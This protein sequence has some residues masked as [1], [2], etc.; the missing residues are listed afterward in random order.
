VDQ[1][2]DA[3]HLRPRLLVGVRLDGREVGGA[4]LGLGLTRE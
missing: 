3:L 4:V 2:V 1:V